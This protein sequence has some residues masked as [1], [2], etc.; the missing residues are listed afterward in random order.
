MQWQT[1]V[2][3]GF[4]DRCLN[5]KWSTAKQYIVYSAIILTVGHISYKNTLKTPYPHVEPPMECLWWVAKIYLCLTDICY[6]WGKIFP[7]I[8]LTVTTIY[9]WPFINVHTN[10]NHSGE[11]PE[12]CNCFFRCYYFSTQLKVF[13]CFLFTHIISVHTLHHKIHG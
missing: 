11:F 8:L 13:Y 2:M 4:P 6:N 9:Y 3:Q 10:S 1:T 12:F 7:W 5:L